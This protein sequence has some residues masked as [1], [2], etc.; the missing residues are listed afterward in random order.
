MSVF[1]GRMPPHSLEAEQSVLGA[2]LLDSDAIQRV[3]DIIEPDDFY[4][5]AHKIIYLAC[6]DLEAAAQPIDLVTLAEALRRENNLEKAGGAVYLTSLAN[7]VPTAANVE[8]YARIIADKALLRHLIRV[9]TIVAQK[10]FEE[11]QRAPE[12]LDEAEAMIFALSN[13]GRKEGFTPLAELIWSSLEV[14]EDRAKNDRVESALPTFQDLDRLLLGL[15][16]GELII[17]AA[18]PGMGKTSFC[19]NIATSVATKSKKP[20]AFFSLEMAK[21]QIAGRVLS[22]E[23]MVDQQSMQSGQLTAE[24]WEKLTLAASKLAGAAVYIDDTPAINPLEL[25][26]KSRRLKAEH[27]LGLVVVDYLQLMQSHRRV[28]N[29]Q[30]E[31]AEISRAL[32][33]LARELE[34]PVLALSQLSRAVEQTHDKRPNLS[35][36]RESGALEQDSDVVMFIHRPE[37]YDPETEKKGLAEIIVA[38]HRNG[39]V[40]TVEMVFLP[41]FTKFVNLAHESGS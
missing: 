19:L 29:R 21:E 23:A 1:E 13:K 2:I 11:G 15:H 34:V 8:H 36:L 38:K 28:E 26:A 16:P 9:A 24:D 35:H 31:I 4:R 32:K 6:L 25:R 39:P 37:Y 20:V 18:R 10:G 41:Q 27:D 12:L 14:M 7:T 17:C 5:D 33:S 30:Q 40:G 3:I 22:S